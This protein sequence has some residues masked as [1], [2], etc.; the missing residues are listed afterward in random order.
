MREQ[1]EAVYVQGWNDAIEACRKAQ[2]VTAE[3]P[4]ESTYQRGFFDGVIAYGRAV[5]QL[6]R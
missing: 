5:L 1:D 2:P 4:D 6:K 3:R